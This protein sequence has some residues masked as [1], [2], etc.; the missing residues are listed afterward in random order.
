MGGKA[1]GSECRGGEVSGST[2]FRTF[3]EQVY[4]AE[5]YRAAWVSGFVSS[6]MVLF[7]SCRDS[8]LTPGF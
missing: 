3:R 7:C 5:I 8:A 2:I 4:I 1:C 6:G